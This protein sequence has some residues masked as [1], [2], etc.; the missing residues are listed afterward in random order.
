MQNYKEILLSAL[1]PT[2]FIILQGSFV[3]SA[4]DLRR[5]HNQRGI[6]VIPYL[7]LLTNC[8]I[9]T[10]YAIMRHDNP[11]LVANL[12]GVFV[13]VGCT[14]VY[15]T[16]SME[17]APSWNF[18][19]ALCLMFIGFLLA[20]SGRTKD[21]G[22]MAMIL[23]ICIYGAPLVTLNRVIEEKSTQSMPFLISLGNF[24]SSVCWTLYGL[25]VTHDVKI[26]VPSIIGAVL[27]SLQM[28]MFVLYGFGP[29]S[30]SRHK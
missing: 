21:E 8:F 6:S 29:P 4:I 30:R 15:Y 3:K 23:S 2:I 7:T 17:Q 12:V 20:V 11:L 10:L 19:V 22:T 1:S 27:A 16:F 13:G 28:F 26:V 18:V 25:I 14:W 9:W 5:D 24:V